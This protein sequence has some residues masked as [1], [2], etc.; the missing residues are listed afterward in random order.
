MYVDFFKLGQGILIFLGI[1][2][3]II[4]I[5]VLLKV[6]STIS[7]VNSIIK[8]NEDNIDEIL[9]ALP[10]TFKNWYEL[11]DNIKDVTEVVVQTTANA[12]GATESFE[13]YLVYIKDILT[14][15]KKIFLNKK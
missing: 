7:S 14:I 3:L 1:I 15:I 5:I 13:K 6:I 12:L 4:L 2:I 8:K 9:S 10:K 11:T